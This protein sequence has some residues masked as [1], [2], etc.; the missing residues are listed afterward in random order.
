VD[1]VFG[2]TGILRR[3]QPLERLRVDV[4]AEVHAGHDAPL[5]LRGDILRDDVVI[6]GGH[7][8]PSRSLFH[9]AAERNLPRFTE[10]AAG[11]GWPKQALEQ[12]K[13][14][15]NVTGGLACA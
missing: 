14:H 7:G 3:G 1:S 2:S 13:H 9:V 11:D 10:G 15:A 4:P 12:V 6:L 8:Q 5:Q